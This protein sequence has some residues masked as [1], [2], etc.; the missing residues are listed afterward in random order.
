MSKRDDVPHGC[1]ILVDTM[2]MITGVVACTG[3][4][5]AIHKKLAAVTSISRNKFPWVYAHRRD[6]SSSSRCSA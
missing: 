3:R 4:V 2:Y 6:G 5:L 1:R